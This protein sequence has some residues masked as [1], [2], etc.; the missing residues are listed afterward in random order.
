MK[1]NSSK[2]IRLVLLSLLLVV[3]L[4]GC[5]DVDAHVTVNSD[6]S[7]SYEITF[8][9]SSFTDQ[10][11]QKDSERQDSLKTQLQNQGFTITDIEKEGQAGWKATKQIDS[12]LDESPTDLVNNIK[13][14]YDWTMKRTASLQAVEG[15]T[16]SGTPSNSGITTEWGLFTTTVNADFRFN[17]LDQNTFSE[18]P[19]SF[20]KIFFDKMNLR[21]H[22]TLPV[23]AT[24]HN[25]TQVSEDGNTLTWK[26]SPT[27][28]NHIH[29][30]K[31]LPNPITWGI[32]LIL[33]IILLIVFL[34]KRKRRRASYR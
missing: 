12:F 26:L 5:V 13:T 3:T 25:A 8:L 21:F 32:I 7:G 4:T 28:E 30:S 16:D 29:L 22:L 23:E 6:L 17:L 18:I 34:R 31:D 2:G 15:S 24:E 14:A 19:E 33:A 20:Q 11:L 27:E 1:I 9:T 10:F